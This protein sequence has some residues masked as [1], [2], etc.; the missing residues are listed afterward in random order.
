MFNH[1]EVSSIVRKIPS[2]H[3]VLLIRPAAS[4]SSKDV[5]WTPTGHCRGTREKLRPPIKK[6]RLDLPVSKKPAGTW[7]ARKADGRGGLNQRAIGVADDYQDADGEAVLSWARPRPRLSRSPL[8]P[9]NV[10]SGARL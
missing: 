2:T 9:Q 1:P 4:Y 10:R 3:N 6:N 7:V 8:P 5:N